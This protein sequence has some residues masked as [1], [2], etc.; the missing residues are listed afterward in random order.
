MSIS[1]ITLHPISL[2]FEDIVSGNSE[3]ASILSLEREYF[4]KYFI[5]ENL[6]FYLCVYH[7]F[8]MR[9]HFFLVNKHFFLLSVIL[10]FVYMYFP[11]QF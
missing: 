5:V 9:K 1:V 6:F 10:C 3:F 8:L 2:Q 11:W 7:D 4:F